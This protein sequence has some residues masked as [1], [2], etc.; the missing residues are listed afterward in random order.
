M[1][2]SR[3]ITCLIP[4]LLNMLFKIYSFIKI[5]KKE[6]RVEGVVLC[7]SIVFFTTLF[8]V[9]FRNTVGL[10]GG[11]GERPYGL[12]APFSFYGRLGLS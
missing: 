3:Q 8:I 7:T 11:V 1:E 2:A 5:R 6:L 9:V 4:V 10:M 12:S